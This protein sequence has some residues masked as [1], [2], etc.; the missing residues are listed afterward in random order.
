VD[1]SEETAPTLRTSQTIGKLA[2][3]IAK[4][5]GELQN[6]ARDRGGQMGNRHYR[7]TTLDAFLDAVRPTLSKYGVALM[8]G[9][10][11]RHY[12][13]RLILG[14]EWIESAAPLKGSDESPQTWG[15]GLTYARRYAYS[16]LLPI[17]SED[18][19]DAQAAEAHH[20]QRQEQRAERTEPALAHDQLASG[21]ACP[22]CGKSGRPSKYPKDGSRFYCFQCK[23][24]F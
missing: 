11:G 16:S 18:D 21:E 15:S 5:M 3:A 23:R 17:A 13:A 19:D 12:C 1:V 14:D 6:V 20:E 2:E 24:A 9:I 10:S 8:G 7:Y 4:A 22:Q